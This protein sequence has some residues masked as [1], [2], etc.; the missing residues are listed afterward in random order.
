M[1]TLPNIT[2]MIK[3]RRKRWVGHVS[4][5]G[6]MRTSYIWPKKPEGQYHFEDLSVVG[7]RILEWI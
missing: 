2:R 4:C 5:M 6:D 1:Y 7:K 3:S